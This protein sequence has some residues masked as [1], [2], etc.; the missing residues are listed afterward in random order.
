DEI[1]E[2]VPTFD[3]RRSG[4][5]VER[6]S[7]DHAELDARANRL[8]C[9]AYNEFFVACRPRRTARKRLLMIGFIFEA[10]RQLAGDKNNCI[11]EFAAKKQIE[12][13]AHSLELRRSS[14]MLDLQGRCLRLF[15]Q[16]P[17]LSRRIDHRQENDDPSDSRTDR[18]EGYPV[19]SALRSFFRC[20]PSLY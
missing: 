6:R 14:Q 11:E 16:R 7:V 20:P 10:L 1:R 3:D 12:D 15:V 9:P 8:E 19:H 13:L 2:R 4:E 17:N 18:A 5:I